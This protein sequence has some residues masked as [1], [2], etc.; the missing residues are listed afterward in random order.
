[1]SSLTVIKNDRNSELNEAVT[2]QIYTAL[3][4]VGSGD[5]AAKSPLT[6]VEWEISDESEN[7]APG[8]KAKGVCRRCLL[9]TP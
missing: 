8:G 2:L 9:Q 3:T 5:V 6:K 1:M 7:Q 4:E